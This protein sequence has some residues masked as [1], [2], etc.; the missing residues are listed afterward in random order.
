MT[1]NSSKK[2]SFSFGK[3]FEVQLLYRNLTFLVFLTLIG[4]LYIANGHRA[5]KKVRK[6]QELQGEIEKGKW[7]YMEYNSAVGY[8]GLQSKT[9]KRVED[10]GLTTGEGSIKIIDQG[11]STEDDE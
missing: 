10:L 2:K 7:R 3:M 8:E 5:E 11:S 1:K 4:I 9:E 6:I